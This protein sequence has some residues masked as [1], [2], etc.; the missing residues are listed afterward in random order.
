MLIFQHALQDIVGRGAGEIPATQ[1]HILQG[2]LLGHM[3]IPGWRHREIHIAQ[4]IAPRGHRGGE[5][6]EQIIDTIASDPLQHVSQIDLVPLL[7][8]EV[9][10]GIDGGLPLTPLVPVLPDEE[11][12]A[13]S[14]GEDVVAMP[15]NRRSSPEEPNSQSP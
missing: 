6:L 8:M 15:P 4:A 12:A 2:D 13:S 10:D 11:I 1:I 14:A 7:R 5:M 9:G 3:T